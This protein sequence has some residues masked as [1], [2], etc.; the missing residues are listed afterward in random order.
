[1][2]LSFPQ[3]A[4]VNDGIDGIDFPLSYSRVDDAIDFIVREG[5][6]MLL[7]KVDIRDAYR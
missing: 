2:D 3:G 4:S 7:A 6:G 1:M 5:R